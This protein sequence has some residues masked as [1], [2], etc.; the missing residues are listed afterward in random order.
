M[1][2]ASLLERA[3]LADGT[4]E[5]VVRRVLAGETALFE[6]V[7]RRHNQRLYRVPG[8]CCAT[9]TR[10]KTLRKIYVRAYRNLVSFEG[11]AAFSYLHRPCTSL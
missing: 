2:S 4:D 10:W 8:P 7:M 6:P 9:T 1:A 3:R 11:R 5:E